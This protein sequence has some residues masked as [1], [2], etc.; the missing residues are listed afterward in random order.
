M[1]ILKR[2]VIAF[3]V[4]V[5]VLL[6][7]GFLLPR[8]VHV[9]RSATIDAPPEVVFAH[10]NDLRQWEAWT[11][12]SKDR[13][14][15]LEL[16]YGDPAAGKGAWYSWT[17]KELGSGKLEIT[18]SQPPKSLD[19][20]LH[21]EGGMGGPAECGFKFEPADGKTNVT[22]HFDADMGVW[23]PGRY[24]GL[25]MDKLLGGDYETGLAKLKKV[26]E[27]QAGTAK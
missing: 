3:V 21:I 13:D 5:V 25:F 18:D 2:I 12:W 24:V 1:L 8:D 10:V 6:G 23:P 26:T 4:L 16:E 19:M 27:K 22:W 11:P 14:A 9:E 15:T 20:L 17:A 7:I